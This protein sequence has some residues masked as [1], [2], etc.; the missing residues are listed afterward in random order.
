MFS[1]HNSNGKCVIHNIYLNLHIPLISVCLFLLDRY[2][3]NLS[4]SSQISKSKV[5]FDAFHLV[6]V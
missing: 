3:I 1:R 6:N 2:E 5:S 4:L